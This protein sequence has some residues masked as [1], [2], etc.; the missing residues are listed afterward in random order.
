[1][2]LTPALR[3]KIL[4]AT[5]KKPKDG[6][7]H[8]S[9][10]KLATA[11]G[12]SKDMVHRVW[13]EAGLKPHRLER[14]LASNDPDFERKAADIIGIRRSDCT[15]PRPILRGSIKLRSGSPKSSVT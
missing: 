2:V 6:S 9:C 11:L 14:Y 12:V 13:R 5:H 10:R 7:T 15:S 3:A 4:A 8:W 1:V